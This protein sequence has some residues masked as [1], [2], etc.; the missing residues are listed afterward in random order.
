MLWSPG[1]IL[2]L[3]AGSLAS[4][5]GEHAAPH[6]GNPGGAFCSPSAPD[7]PIPTARLLSRGAP[8]RGASSPGLEH[9]AGGRGG[10]T[11]E[12]QPRPPRTCRSAAPPDTSG[13]PALGLALGP[14]DLLSPRQGRLSARQAAPSSSA[15]R[16]A[17]AAQPEPASSS[18][19]DRRATPSGA[20]AHRAPLLPGGSGL[21]GGRARRPRQAAVTWCLPWTSRCCARSPVQPRHQVPCPPRL[22]PPQSPG[23]VCAAGLRAPSCSA[24]LPVP[25]PGRQPPWPPLLLT[26]R[27]GPGWRAVGEGSSCFAAA[28]SPCGGRGGPVRR[29]RPMLPARTCPAL[30]ADETRSPTLPPPPCGSAPRRAR[31]RALPRCRFP[32]APG[33]L[34]LAL[35][36]PER[37]MSCLGLRNVPR[38][39]R[40][41]EAAR[42]SPNVWPPLSPGVDAGGDGGYYLLGMDHVSAEVSSG[43]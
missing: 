2:G 18:P 22:W 41:V 15:A 24:L 13:G 14:P 31:G 32:S 17:V 7:F 9:S 8:D 29:H 26:L 25:R 10:G 42:L 1:R 33:G 37:H 27:S 4:L 3:G 16:G 39:R 43:P 34:V 28:R 12:P 38:L 6:A 19:R 21:I 40:P 11:A 36:S 35:T 30:G 20:R 5:G 23:K